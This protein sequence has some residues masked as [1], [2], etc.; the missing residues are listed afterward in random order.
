MMK[1]NRRE[2]M[3]TVTDNKLYII[4]AVLYLFETTLDLIM[5]HRIMFGELNESL[6]KII[7]F[8]SI[9]VISFTMI[10]VSL[11]MREGWK[12]TLTAFG[13][14]TVGRFVGMVKTVFSDNDLDDKIRFILFF[15]IAASATCIFFCSHIGDRDIR[16]VMSFLWFIP[17]VLYII[18]HL[19]YIHYY[20]IENPIKYV[21]KNGY[22]VTL[23]L[24]LFLFAATR[25]RKAG[26]PVAPATPA[27]PAPAPMPGTP[28]SSIGHGE[29][30]EEASIGTV[31]QPLPV[32]NSPSHV[33][34]TKHS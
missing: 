28:V 30:V 2:G 25:P 31:I 32:E 10:G 16:K 27:Q 17:G 29:G 24:F 13:L 7:V 18:E 15:L 21:I 33:D 14:L 3:F 6:F 22:A 23:A 20:E 8:Y 11:F 12:I 5:L 34:L 26:I 19:I 1:F 9:E 4:A